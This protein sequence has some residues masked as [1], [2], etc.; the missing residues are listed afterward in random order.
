MHMPISIYILKPI[1]GSCIDKWKTS[2]TDL[3]K[4][5]RSAYVYISICSKNQSSYIVEI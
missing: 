4:T 2:E 3:L 1:K 5:G